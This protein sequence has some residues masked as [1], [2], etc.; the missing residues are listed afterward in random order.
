MNVM[1][2]HT[3]GRGRKGILRCRGRGYQENR[4]EIRKTSLGL[5]LFC[6]FGPIGIKILIYNLGIDVSQHV[7]AILDG[8]RQ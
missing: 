7:H 4:R 8:S 2:L 5:T 6:D 3:H 1:T